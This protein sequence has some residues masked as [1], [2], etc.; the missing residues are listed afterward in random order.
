MIML[1][2]DLFAIELILSI[3]ATL[4][5]LTTSNED[6]LRMGL[7]RKFDCL[8]RRHLRMTYALHLGLSERRD[9]FG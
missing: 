4:R 2:Q 8:R 7:R 1:D 6:V 3:S 9:L 5:P